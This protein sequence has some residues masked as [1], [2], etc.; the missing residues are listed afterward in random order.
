M[1]AQPPEQR[2]KHPQKAVAQMVGGI[3]EAKQ[4]AIGQIFSWL[5]WLRQKTIVEPKFKGSCE[6][7]PCGAAKLC[8]FS[9]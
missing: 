1:G 8:E 9:L 4:L 6:R 2:D 5:V 3:A 7:W